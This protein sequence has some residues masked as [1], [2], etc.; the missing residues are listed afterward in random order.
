MKIIVLILIFGVVASLKNDSN[1]EWESYKSKHK[2]TYSS[3]LE[4]SKRRSLWEENDKIIKQH[5]I[6]AEAGIHSYKQGH[7]HL[8]DRTPEELSRLLGKKSPKA[9]KIVKHTINIS[10]RKI[11]TLPDSIDWRKYGAVTSIRNQ[12]ICGSCWAHAAVA[13][14]EGQVFIKTGEL[15]ELSEQNFVDCTPSNEKAVPNDCNGGIVSDAYLYAQNGINSRE[16]YPYVSG[17]SLKRGKCRKN[18]TVVETVDPYFSG[19]E[20]GGN[21]MQLKQLVATIGPIAVSLYASLKSFKNY[22]SGIYYDPKCGNKPSKSDH[23]VTVV[24]YGS[25]GPGKDYWLI[26]NS[27]DTEWG[28]E[29][30]AKMARNRKN[31]C[32]IA[33]EQVYPII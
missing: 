16:K 3:P 19:R 9:P 29:G 28:L 20:S 21:E 32:G 6:E 18:H 30:F 22:E 12:Q 10:E 33:F 27:W 23:Y 25:D 5:N 2:K 7:N 11:V 4:E 15:V 1:V 13:A 26:K 14:L 8:S 17:L 24:G 31:W